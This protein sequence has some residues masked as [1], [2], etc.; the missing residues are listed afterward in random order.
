M[1]AS[2]GFGAPNTPPY[3]FYQR[4]KPAELLRPHRAPIAGLLVLSLGVSSLAL[5]QYGGGTL[6]FQSASA[7]TFFSG[8]SIWGTATGGIGAPTS[9]TIGGVNYQYLTFTSTGTLTVTRAG[10]FDYCAIAGGTGS[11]TYTTGGFAGGG[12]G[13]AGA[14]STTGTAGTAGAT[15][16]GTGYGGAGGGGGGSGTAGVGGAGGAGGA[17]GGGGGGGGAGTSANGGAGGVGGVGYAQIIT[18]N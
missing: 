18:F 5:A 4:M 14:S 15:G 3:L 6:R 16:V 1:P 10:F 9:V 2:K 8:T 13:A 12:G 17:S 11:V 7:A